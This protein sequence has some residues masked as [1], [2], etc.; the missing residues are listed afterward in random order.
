MN[1]CVTK[2]DL[3]A[4]FQKHTKENLGIITNLVTFAKI[5]GT[6]LAFLS[7]IKKPSWNVNSRAKG[8]MVYDLNL[9]R[10]LKTTSK[11]AYITNSSS[12]IVKGTDP[13][14]IF[15]GYPNFDMF[16]IPNISSNL[17]LASKLTKECNCISIFFK[18]FV[19]FPEVRMRKETGRGVQA[20]SLYI[21]ESFD[22]G[23]VVH[24]NKKRF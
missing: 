20:R 11:H 15:L 19:I 1:N 7:T 12:I 22:V 13:I 23:L 6:K 2:D 21:M 3:E 8:H 18:K 10:D 9:V 16:Y 17:I 14:K 4:S 5:E 24:H